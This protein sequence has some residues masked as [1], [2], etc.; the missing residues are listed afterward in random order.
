VSP[1][2]VS[3]CAMVAL[4]GYMI[5]HVPAQAGTTRIDIAETAI[6]IPPADFEF[7][8]TGEGE[9]GQWVVVSDPTTATGL[10][11]EHVSADQHEDRFP[12]AIYTP[13]AL[14]N[15][16]LTVRF[17][18]VS[19]TMLRA[20]MAVGVRDYGNYYSV[21][22]SALEQRVDLSLFQ[23]GQVRRLESLD[24]DIARGRWYTLGLA[25]NDDH[26]TVSL[27]GKL[28]FTAFDR[29]RGKDGHIALW[30]QEDNVTRFD[31]IEICSPPTAD[32]GGPL[33]R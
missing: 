31:Q 17:K 30:T 13:L 11:I 12:L 21:S 10:A 23:N 28:L 29:S 16:R 32:D 15:V 20:G 22:A 3:A 26:F 33:C 24:A 7:G 14:E 5:V 2:L 1:G 19:G 25:V 18:I 8:L 6:G 27:D 9:L 4:M